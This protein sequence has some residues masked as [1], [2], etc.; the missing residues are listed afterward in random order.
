MH[1]RC[2]ITWKRHATCHVTHP[3]VTWF[4]H[5]VLWMTVT[6]MCHDLRTRIHVTRIHVTHI[7]ESHSHTSL[8]HMWPD[9]FPTGWQRPIWCL[10]S[11]SRFSRKS[12]IISGFFVKRNLQP[13]A[14]P[15]VIGV[16]LLA[17]RIVRVLAI[18]FWL[19]FSRSD[20]WDVRSRKVEQRKDSCSS[21]I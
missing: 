6:H 5:I 1:V 10:I 13:G 15:R 19:N 8:I 2:I 9:S 21:L 18:L 16:G 3:H 14:Q 4:I 12:P 11:T 17:L 7:N 20:V